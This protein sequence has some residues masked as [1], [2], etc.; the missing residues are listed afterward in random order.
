MYSYAPPFENNT[1]AYNSYL[2]R[3]TGMSTTLKLSDLTDEQIRTLA[4]AIRQVEGWQEGIIRQ[5]RADTVNMAIMQN[6]MQKTL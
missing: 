4:R 3:L 1:A 2:R 5:I 6:K